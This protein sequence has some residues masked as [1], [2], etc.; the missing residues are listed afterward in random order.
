MVW[1]FRQKFGQPVA[2]AEILACIQSIPGVV[3]VRLTEIKRWD[4]VTEEEEISEQVK[5]V[6]A[7]DAYWCAETRTIQRAELLLLNEGDIQFQEWQP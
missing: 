3:A 7:R 1:F 2:P 6:A 4:P 5:P